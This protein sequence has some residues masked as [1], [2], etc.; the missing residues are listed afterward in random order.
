ME[1][2]VF[3]TAPLIDWQ[4]WLNQWRHEYKLEVLSNELDGLGNS[5]ILL[6]RTLKKTVKKK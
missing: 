5:T 6:K 4:K 3:R 1:D 2:Y